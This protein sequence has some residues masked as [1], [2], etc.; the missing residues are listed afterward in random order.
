MGMTNI[1]IF[2]FCQPIFYTFF[3]SPYLLQSGLV[4]DCTSVVT[5][6][7]FD[8]PYL[9]DLVFDL[10]RLNLGAVCFVRL[11]DFSKHKSRLIVTF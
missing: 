9:R 6:R 2:H 8:P 1:K 3:V 11:S 4:V 10:R 5:N 7:R